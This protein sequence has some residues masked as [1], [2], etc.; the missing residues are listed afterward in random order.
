[1]KHVSA[2]FVFC[3]IF[4][5]GSVYSQKTSAPKFTS[6]YTNLTSDCKTIKGGEGT[7]DASDCKGAGGYRINIS[8]AAAVLSISAQ[9]PDKNSSIPIATQGFE[10][11]Q[12]KRKIE[13]RL[14]DGKPFA[15]IMR[16]AKY[17]EPDEE[18]PYLGKK[19]G[20]ELVV[21]GLQGFEEINFKVDAKT[22]NAN[23]KA[24]ELADNGYKP[25]M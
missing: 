8:A 22:P 9:T 7:D 4:L 20:E 15:V 12:T 3:L 2:L 13:W 18:N 17:G 16:V 25:K 19:T 23:Q 10:F 1:M 21:V 6:A 24:R 11:D 5:T 14:A